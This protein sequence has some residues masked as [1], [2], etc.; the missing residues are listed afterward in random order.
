MLPWLVE[1]GLIT[2]ATVAPS[3][4]QSLGLGKATGNFAKVGP[5]PAPS[6]FVATAIVFGPLALLSDNAQWGKIASLTAWGIVLATLLNVISPTNPI[7]PC[8]PTPT[9][10]S[11]AT[12]ATG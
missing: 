10:Q 5:F 8:T 3:A 1:I 6:N 9:P 2:T 11:T 12:A 7:K 4:F